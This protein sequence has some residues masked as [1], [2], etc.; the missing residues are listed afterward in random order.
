MAGTVASW[1]AERLLLIRRDRR[2]VEALLVRQARQVRRALRVGLLKR[3]HRLRGLV[4]ERLQVALLRLQRPAERVGGVL[5]RA[6]LHDDLAILAGDPVERVEVSERVGDRGG[7]EHDREGVAVARLVHQLQPRRERVLL[8]S[9]GALGNVEPL[10]RGGEV[11]L[12]L[13]AADAQLHEAG[14]LSRQARIE[15][16]QLEHDATRAPR[17]VRVLLGELRRVVTKTGGGVGGDRRRDDREE[18]EQGPEDGRPI[19]QSACLSRHDAAPY[20]T[21]L[22]G[23]ARRRAFDPFGPWERFAVVRSPC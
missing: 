14:L 2:G 20:H 21:T 9:Q 13:G 22:C 16:V 12:D 18:H 4:G 19:P 17:E 15:R 10:A 8:H 23:P 11:G 6:R 1:R 7:P 5:R 3:R